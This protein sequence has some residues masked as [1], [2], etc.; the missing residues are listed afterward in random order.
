M[1]PRIL[2]EILPHLTRLVPAADKFL[3]SR[4]ASDKAQEEALA[5]LADHVRDGISGV[6]EEQ[7]GLR[8]QLQEQSEQIGQVGVE[9]TRARMGVESI[10]ARITKLEQVSRTATRLQWVVLVLVGV[11]A[12]LAV[13]ILVKGR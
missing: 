12:V 10:E 3:A 1:W 7:A 5:A 13:V 2:L 8:R 9:V 6:A 4:N 11:V